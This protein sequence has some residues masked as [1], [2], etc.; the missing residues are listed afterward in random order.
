MSTSIRR[1]MIEDIGSP[2][3]PTPL[4][5]DAEIEY[6]QS[7]GTS[8]FY[9]DTLISKPASFSSVE[10]ITDVQFISTNDR[11]IHGATNALY[12][13]VNSG[14]WENAYGTYT[15]GANTNRHTMSKKIE[16]SGSDK[17]ITVYVD[18]TRTLN[19][20]NLFSDSDWNANIGVFSI[21]SSSPS[22]YYAKIYSEKIYVNGNLVRDY[23]PVRVGQVGYMYDRI[24]RQLFGNSGTGSFVLGNDKNS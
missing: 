22:G 9:I 12:F 21:S 13:G 18:S 24:S 2:V 3:S 15:N 7:T 23:I 17:I 4:P 19:T 14:R 5:Y 6:L 20:Q 8:G 10:I 11:Q 16:I 1:R